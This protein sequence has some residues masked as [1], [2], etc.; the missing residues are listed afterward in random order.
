MCV[1]VSCVSVVEVDGVQCLLSMLESPSFV[2][3]VSGRVFN[4]SSGELG[5][6]DLCVCMC[7][8][9]YRNRC[10]VYVCVYVCVCAC[11]RVCVYSYLFSIPYLY[12]ILRNFQHFSY[13]ILIS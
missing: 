9:V 12:F 10:C 8:C 5:V 11:V 7:V 2:V 13:S 3:C 1:S 4:A 6:L